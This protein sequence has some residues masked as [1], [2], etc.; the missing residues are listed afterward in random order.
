MLSCRR[1]PLPMRHRNDPED[2]RVDLLNV[3]CWGSVPVE[4]ALEVA[5]IVQDASE[6]M[7]WEGSGRQFSHESQRNA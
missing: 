2:C 4:L 6:C 7:G 3:R 1:F 5:G